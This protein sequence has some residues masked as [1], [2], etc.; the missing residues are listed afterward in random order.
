VLQVD[1]PD[2]AMERHTSYADRPLAEFLDFL[3]LNVA[4]INHALGAVPPDRVRLHVCWGNY[5]GPHDHDVPLDDLLDRLYAARVGALVLSMANPR[6]EHEHKA[7]RRHPL[8]KDWLLVAGVIDTTTN[9]IEHPEGI[10]DRLERA[11]DAVG[12]PRRV[13]AGTD[14]GFDTAAGLGE[15]AEEVVWKKLEALRAGADLATRRLLGA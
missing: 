7:L 13:L 15:V 8:P 12:D 1:A 10:A 14:C 9:Y 5:E 11:A 3:E 4:A 2:L 6:H